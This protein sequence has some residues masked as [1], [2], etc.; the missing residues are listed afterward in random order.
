[1]K[2]KSYLTHKCNITQVNRGKIE[3]SRRVHV[4]KELL[5]EGWCAINE[6]QLCSIRV[7]DDI[8]NAAWN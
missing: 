6:C 7:L 1:M 2:L 3:E 4:G 8:D 5:K